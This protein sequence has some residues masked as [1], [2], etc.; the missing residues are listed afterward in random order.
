MEQP[1]VSILIPTHNRLDLFK[2]AFQSAISQT[3]KNLEIVISDDSDDDKT[4]QYMQAYLHDKRIKYKLN[5]GFN[6]AQNWQ[7]LIEHC[8]GEYINFLMDDDIFA[9]EK[10]EKMV[11]VY[12]QYPNISLVTSHRQIID[13]NGNHMRDASVTRPIVDRSSIISGKT[14]ANE[15]LRTNM[16]FIGEPTTVLFKAKYREMF[17]K[18]IESH[19]PITD[20]RMW[21]ELCKEGDVAYLTDTLSYFRLHDGNGQNQPLIILEGFIDWNRLYH[22]AYRKAEDA[23][24]KEVWLNW[25]VT[26]MGKMIDLW[27]WLSK[28]KS[29]NQEKVQRYKHEVNEVI[30]VYLKEFKGETDWQ[31]APGVKEFIEAYEAE[32]KNKV[33]LARDRG[34]MK[35]VILAGGRGTRITEESRIKPKPMVEIGGMPILWHIMKEYSAYGINDFIICAGYKQEVIKEWFNNYFLYTNDVTFHFKENNKVEFHNKSTEPWTVTIA[36]TGEDTM[37]GGRI[38]RIAPYIQEEDFLMT[39]GDAVCDVNIGDLIDFHRQS[40]K[41][42]TLTTVMQDQSKGVLNIAYDNSVRSFREKS[43]KDKVPIN[44]GYMVLNRK[45]FDYIYGD[46]C[47]FEKGPLEQL[48]KEGQLMSYQHRGYWQCMDTLL[49]KE[50]LEETWLSGKAPWK[51]WE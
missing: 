49:E 35:A 2:I 33:Q 38:K 48:A 37:T 47:V 4:Y 22:D 18:I 19:S 17:G 36:D 3:Y 50:I 11:A 26:L 25:Y 32:N 40:G 46:M 13:I 45:I 8:Q 12:E 39:Y 16:N 7:W 9:P 42:A 34:G 15:L 30:R 23:E 5:R 31:A 10:I 44:A 27:I 6:S 1:L 43:I 41:I 20:V 28:D 51:T 14:I 24:T 21:L 29:Q